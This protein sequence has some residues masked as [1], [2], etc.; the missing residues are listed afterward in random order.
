[1]SDRFKCN[2]RDADILPEHVWDK[3]SATFSKDKE[4]VCDI[5]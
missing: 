1:M 4:K 2:I 3:M 5:V